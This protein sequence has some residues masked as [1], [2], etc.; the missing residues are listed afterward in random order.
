M[1]YRMLFACMCLPLDLLHRHRH[2]LPFSPHHRRLI[3]KY[4]EKKRW[5]INRNHL[6]HDYIFRRQT[7]QNFTF[8]IN[9]VT[10]LDSQRVD[11]K[12]N[13]FFLFSCLL[14][15]FFITNLSIFF[16]CQKFFSLITRVSAFLL[17][18][19]FFFFLFF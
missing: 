16:L 10:H 19:F 17:L 13:E 1:K 5:F 7:K 3:L 8:I 2:R 18:F 15:S 9:R 11:R 14:F 12:L 6:Q 4:D